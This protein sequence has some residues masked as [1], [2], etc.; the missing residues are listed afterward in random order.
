[1]QMLP[2]PQFKRL[3]SPS[4]KR[5]QVRAARLYNAYSY[6]ILANASYASQFSYV[7]ASVGRKRNLMIIDSDSD[8]ENN[9]E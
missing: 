6:D 1:M 9:N 8:D 2:D 5:G 3:T 4:I 7:S